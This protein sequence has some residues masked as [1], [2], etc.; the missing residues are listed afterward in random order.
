MFLHDAVL[1]AVVCGETEIATDK[2]QLTLQKLKEIDP[3]TGLTGLQSQ[4]DLLSQ[5]APDPVHVLCDTAKAHKD[6]NR[7]NNFLPREN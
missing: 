1:E 5:V 6:K 2:Y 3:Q 4:F 7:S